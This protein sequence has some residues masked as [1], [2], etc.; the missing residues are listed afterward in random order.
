MRHRRNGF[1]L[2]EL[3]VVIAIIAILAAILFPVFARARENA[4]KTNCLSN[5]K[6]IGLGFMQYAQDYD[7]TMPLGCGS[8][9][10][11]G[12]GAARCQHV[13]IFPY[14]KNTQV[15]VCPS[16]AGGHA[17]NATDQVDA[18]ERNFRG[19]YVINVPARYKKLATIQ[20]PA[21]FIH[22]LDGT[23]GSIVRNSSGCCTGRASII[24]FRHMDGANVL[25]MDGHA[26]WRK[27][28]SLLTNT[29][30]IEWEQ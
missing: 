24:A 14:L 27:Q 30:S 5:L 17:P 21:E 1:T 23:Q 3:L 7:E 12:S 15:W 29:G 2:I 6:Q 10:S 13:A 4:R 26:K 19:S 16:E 20:Q 22:L 8:R 18:L 9:P 25:F 11:Q 28:D